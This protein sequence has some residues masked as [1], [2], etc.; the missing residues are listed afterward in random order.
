MT[1]GNYQRLSST[2][3]VEE[4]GD[5]DAVSINQVPKFRSVSNDMNGFSS[6]IGTNRPLASG[7]SRRP[8]LSGA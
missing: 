3:Q 4:N 6:E 1:S 2:I 5:L 8:G 7:I